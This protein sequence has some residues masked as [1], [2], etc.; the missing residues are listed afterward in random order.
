MANQRL[1]YL[2]EKIQDK[3]KSGD[4]YRGTPVYNVSMSD[5]K[6]LQ[7]VSDKYGFPVEWLANLINHETAGTYNPAITNSI[8]A[9][10]LIQFLPSTASTYGTTT[11]KLRKMSFSQQLDYVEK[12]LDKGLKS[13][14]LLDENGKVKPT[15]NQGDL[16]MLIFYPVSV[17][18]PNYVFPSNVQAANSVS[19]PK[20]YT[21]KALRNAPF[22]L[23]LAPFS[24]QEYIQ[25]YGQ[26]ATSLIKSNKKWWLLPLSI[27][28]FGSALITIIWYVKKKK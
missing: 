15:F 22:S 3:R 21:Q 5:L 28:I 1:T 25:K 2:Y 10:G 9:T 17:G 7:N 24:L 18:N 26:A 6:K 13:K 23:D 11:E 12:Y 27:L 4:T 8:G 20:E 14:D 16:F 19:T